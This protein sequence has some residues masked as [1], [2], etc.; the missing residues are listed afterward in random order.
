VRGQFYTGWLLEVDLDFFLLARA[1]FKTIFPALIL[2]DFEFI[3][4]FLGGQLILSPHFYILGF[5]MHF[6][7]FDSDLFSIKN[8]LL[9]LLL[10]KEIFEIL[11]NPGW[12][13][14]FDS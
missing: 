10:K 9:I 8:P 11:E 1:L 3:P 6:F 2:S 4:L 12:R 13:H 5:Y 14:K 7:F